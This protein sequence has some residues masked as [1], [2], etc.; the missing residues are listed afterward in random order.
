MTLLVMSVGDNIIFDPS[1]QELAVA[2]AVVAVSI[3][4]SIT[5]TSQRP[6]GRSD[7]VK[8]LSL[9]TI[10]PPSRLTQPGIPDAINTATGGT[11]PASGQD[12]IALKEAR[13]GVGDVW[14]PPR[15]GM[16]RA[17]LRRMIDE[18]CREGGLGQDVLASLDGIDV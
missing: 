5:T 1:R 2:E 9:R 13:S 10:D 14:T 8:L 11:A 15:G 12:A 3:A 4:S 6:N 16:K 17:T 18:V 7:A